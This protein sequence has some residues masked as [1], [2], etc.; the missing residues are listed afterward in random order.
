MDSF[1]VFVKEPSFSMLRKREQKSVAELQWLSGSQEDNVLGSVRPCV[2]PS[3]CLSNLSWLN[4]LT[5]D[6][7]YQSEVFVCV[8]YNRADAV[9]RLL[10]VDSLTPPCVCVSWWMGH[11]LY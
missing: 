8:S 7:D 1:E 9:D 5:Y 2:R 10:I 4:R 6:L 3:V 11:S